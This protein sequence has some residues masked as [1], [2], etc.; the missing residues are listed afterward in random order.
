M[1]F[2]GVGLPEI[3]LILVVAVIV[4]G[5]ERIPALAVQIAKGIRLLRGYANDTTA[6]LRSELNDL[7]REYNS[8]REELKEFRQ[9]LSTGV[10]SVTGEI[11]QVL[12]ETE[13][14]AGS[15]QG[16]GNNG[17]SQAKSP[18]S[19]PAALRAAAGLAEP[20]SEGRPG[21]G[22]G[23]AKEDTDPAAEAAKTRREFYWFPDDSPPM[24]EPSSE[25]DPEDGGQRPPAQ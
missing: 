7:T 11:D 17:Q 4:V 18:G 12:K 8:V 25:P 1:N 2:L 20:P 21:Q 5:P 13:A 6:Q 22:V 23:T 9:A 16:I 10:S 15:V 24:I 3:V 14:A 19:S